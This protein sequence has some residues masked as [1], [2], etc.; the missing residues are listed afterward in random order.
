MGSV[1]KPD[2]ADKETL[3]A[4]GSGTGGKIVVPQKKKFRLRK[5]SDRIVYEHS[6]KVRFQ[7]HITFF[8]FVY[9]MESLRFSK[10]P[11]NKCG[12]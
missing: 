1:K 9:V 8:K 3:P 10:M 11:Q 12:S 5:A 4:P 7:N 6:H 2:I